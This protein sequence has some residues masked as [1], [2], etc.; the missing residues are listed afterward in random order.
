MV[1]PMISLDECR[2]LLGD[3]GRHLSDSELEGLRGEVYG[4]AHIAIKVFLRNRNTNPAHPAKEPLESGFVPFPEVHH[5][6]ES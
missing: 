2:E 4:L 5:S 3:A 1:S 6:R